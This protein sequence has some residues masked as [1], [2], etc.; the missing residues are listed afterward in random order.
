V[1]V[2]FAGVIALAFVGPLHEQALSGKF[3]DQ[4]TSRKVM[5]QVTIEGIKQSFP[6][7][8]GLGTMPQVYRTLEDQ[9][10]I[11]REVVNHTHN[12]YLEFVLELGILG[13]L[14]ILGFFIWWGAQSLKL[15]RSSSPGGDLGRVGSVI[16]LVVLF[17]SLVDYPIRTSAIA[18]LFATACA[19]IM[20]PWGVPTG[21]K[22]SRRKTAEPEAA[23]LRHLEAD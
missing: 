21:S 12:D 4:R 19:L 6:V 18:A 9:N 14:L 10:A 23:D 15:W 16:I 22:R 7:G 11:G 17:H 20:Q 13:A 5:A 2:V 1:A 3:T 8:T